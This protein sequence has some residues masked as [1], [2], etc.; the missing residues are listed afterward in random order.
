M[1]QQV[2]NPTSIHG[3]AGLI[4]GFVSGLTIALQVPFGALGAC[5]KMAG[6]GRSHCGSGVKNPTSIHEDVGS[7]PSLAQW[8]TG[9]SVI[10]SC[11]VDH[12]SG[13]DLE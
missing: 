1:A 2:T 7:I 9:S 13:S 11:G 4:P 8:V 10:T 5:L 6:Y 12:R 3:E